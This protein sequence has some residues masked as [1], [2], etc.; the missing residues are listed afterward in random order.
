M[1]KIKDE[2]YRFTQPFDFIVQFIVKW[3]V[4]QGFLISFR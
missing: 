2:N 4:L 3:A 1:Q